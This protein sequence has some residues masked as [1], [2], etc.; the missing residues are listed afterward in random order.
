MSGRA[1]ALVAADRVEALS[2]TMATVRPFSTLVD[3]YNSIMSDGI[4]CLII[5]VIDQMMANIKI[6]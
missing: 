1:T 2:V 3:I 5:R 4:E 6:G